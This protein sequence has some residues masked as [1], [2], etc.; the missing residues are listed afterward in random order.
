MQKAG[1]NIP[2]L[3]SVKPLQLSSSRQPSSSLPRYLS[4]SPWQFAHRCGLLRKHLLP[5]QTLPSPQICSWVRAFSWQHSWYGLF[6]GFLQA[7]SFPP[8]RS[9]NCGFLKLRACSLSFFQSPFTR[10]FF[11]LSTCFSTKLSSYCQSTYYDSPFCIFYII[12]YNI[13]FSF[14]QII[15]IFI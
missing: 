3:C 15:P 5:V 7:I 2:R 8:L 11:T 1:D 14:W 10:P 12:N 4:L 13:I 9:H 6:S